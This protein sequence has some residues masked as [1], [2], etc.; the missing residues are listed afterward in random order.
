MATNK[1]GGVIEVLNIIGKVTTNASE[2]LGYAI[3]NVIMPFATL[4]MSNYIS[5]NIANA[6]ASTVAALFL[7]IIFIACCL[8]MVISIPVSIAILISS[9]VGLCKKRNAVKNVIS[10]LF[11]L[12][13]FPIVIYVISILLG[14][15]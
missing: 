12:A 9:I 14:R 6:D 3:T 13:Y 2:R 15:L 5:A 4:W 10:L 7:G 11:T 1:T 8:Y